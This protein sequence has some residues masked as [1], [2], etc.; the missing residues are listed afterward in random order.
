M[1]LPTHQARRPGLHPAAL[2]GKVS[3]P[4]AVKR[5]LPGMG[6]LATAV[7]AATLLA[8]CTPSGAAEPDEPVPQ[9]FAACAPL[10]GSDPAAP[11][12]TL[13][14]SGTAAPSGTAVA[15]SGT[16]AAT[17]GTGGAGDGKA[18]VIRLPELS[19]D[20]M[21]GGAAVRLAELRGPLVINLWA[22]WCPPC[23]KELP[24]FQRLADSGRVPVLGVVTEDGRD[25]AAW[26]ADELKVSLPTVYD[27]SG[28]LKAAVGENLLPLTLFVGADGRATVYR[29]VALTDQTLAQRVEQ[30]FG[31][32]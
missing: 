18:R 20:C 28:G 22:S 8:G 6:A 10:T 9:P 16:A 11:N 15:T 14:S 21:A 29:D 5:R 2:S 7:A 27:R 24:A 1:S 12:S 23:R 19:L 4:A 30:H 26:L 31:R 3:P 17:S 25:A 32:A 13:P